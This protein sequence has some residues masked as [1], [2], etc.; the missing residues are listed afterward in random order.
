M[1]SVHH[2]SSAILLAIA[3]LSY[4]N[5]NAQNKKS[6]TVKIQ[7]SAIC[8]MCKER[9]EYELT[10]EKGVKYAELNLENKVVTVEYN[11]KKTDIETLRKRISLTGYHADSVHRNVEAYNELPACCQDG[12]H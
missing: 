11:P 1:K 2:I 4:K 3:L 12:G 10:Y 8:E 5:L 6:D 9:I 7:T